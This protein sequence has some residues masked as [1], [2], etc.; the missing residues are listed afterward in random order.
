MK[1]C[2]G[3]LCHTYDTKDRK[4]GPKGNKQNQTR[5]RTSF[6]F[7]KGNACSMKC[8]GDWFDT[9][10]ERAVNYFGRITQP[11]VLTE[12]NAGEKRY[13]WAYEN[14][15]DRYYMYNV[16]TGE[17][18]PLTDEQFNDDNYTLNT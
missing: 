5:R 4:R 17:Q 18:R 11:I 16:C 3:P 7:L 10:G 9:Y 6:Y 14:P 13:R 1:Y 12:N 2:Q 15:A 8:Q